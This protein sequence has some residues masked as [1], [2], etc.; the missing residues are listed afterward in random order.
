MVRADAGDGADAASDVLS[1]QE[2]ENFSEWDS[3]P[4]S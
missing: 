3:P 4:E 2:G 1:R